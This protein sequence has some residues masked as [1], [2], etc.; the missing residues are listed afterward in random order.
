MTQSER[1]PNRPNRVPGANY[2]RGPGTVDP[3]LAHHLALKREPIGVFVLRIIAVS[4]AVGILAWAWRGSAM[5]PG[6]LLSDEGRRAAYEHVFGKPV[7][8]ASAERER[9]RARDMVEMRLQEQAVAD[10]WDERGLEGN[11]PPPPGFDDQVRARVDALRA[12]MGPEAYERAVNRRYEEFLRSKRGG[13]FP[14]ETR[15]IRVFGDPDTIARTEREI[16]RGVEPGFWQRVVEG[17]RSDGEPTAASRAAAWV[18]V[19]LTG[20][21]YTGLLLQTIAIAL[22]GT[23]LTVVTAVPAAFLGAEKSMRL[24]LPG[25]GLITRTVRGAI[26]FSTRRAFDACRGFN[27]IVLALIFVAIVGLGPFAGVLALAIHSFGV[28]GKVLSEAIETCRDGEIEGVL[29]TGARPA[30]VASY[31]IV[32]QILP[33]VVSQSLLRFETNVRSATVLGIVGAGGVGFLI[34]AKIKSYN[35]G[36]VATIMLMVII[37]VS[38]IDYVCGRL[39]R[40]FV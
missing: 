24:F 34:D 27:E 39:M 3:A 36:E 19:A 29:A 16:E 12:E 18:A 31:A 5:D 26:V 8:D 1:P 23:L 30:Q 32:P 20:N 7:D 22:W 15:P 4:V 28:L 33:Y 10:V 25:E 11:A 6:G 17:L 38:L 2:A 21:S 14:I 35:Y 40:R 9:E 13:Y 37:T